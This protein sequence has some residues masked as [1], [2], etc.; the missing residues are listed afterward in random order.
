METEV[1]TKFNVIRMSFALHG[2]SASLKFNFHE[3]VVN[4]CYKIFYDKYKKINSTKANHTN[5]LL[6]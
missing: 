4:S 5:L 3:I 2:Y 6:K 1:N